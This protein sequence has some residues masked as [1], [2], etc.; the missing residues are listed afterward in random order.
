MRLGCQEV[1]VRKVK[2][3]QTVQQYIK[4][5]VPLPPS[6]T[7]HTS[8]TLYQSYVMNHQPVNLSSSQL[9]NSPITQNPLFSNTDYIPHNF[10]YQQCNAVLL[11]PI[12]TK[13]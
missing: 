7:A 9:F 11:K 8:C 1:Q 2:C 5:T 10:K 4:P 13:L 6:S 3:P 12:A